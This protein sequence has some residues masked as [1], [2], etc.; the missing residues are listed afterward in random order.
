[1]EISRNMELA[2][3]ILQAENQ[4]VLKHFCMDLKGEEEG[5]QLISGFY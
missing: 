3:E 5:P 1:M 4:E 2:F